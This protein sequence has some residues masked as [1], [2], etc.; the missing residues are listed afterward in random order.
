MTTAQLAHLRA[1]AEAAGRRIDAFLAEQPQLALSRTAVQ[2]LIEAG[3]VRVGGRPVRSSLKLSGGEEIEVRVPPPPAPEARAEDIPLRVVYEDADLIVVDKPRGMVVHPAAGHARGTLVNALLHHCPDLSGVGGE[4]RPGIVHRLDKG[5]TGLIVAAKNDAAHHSLAAQI[6]RR[7]AR[8]EY[9]ALVYGSPDADRGL[10]DAPIGR[11]PAHRQRMAV[12][13]HRGRAARTHFQVRERF[14]G[15]GGSR[16]H[17][18][19][20]C[21]L[22]TGRT[23]QVRVHLASIGHPV[24]ADPLYAPSRPTL[25]LGGQALHAFR[26]AF[27]HPRT[28]RPLRFEVPL[29][30]DFQA[31][32]DNLRAALLR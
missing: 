1:P 15:R 12:V 27:E 2:R 8:R 5:T 28:G 3:R 25:G 14:P 4:L 9:L 31:V 11:D 19:L 20:E 13:A 7:T 22:E 23:H 24:V 30:P 21:R 32:V 6:K 29:P 18:L 16:G 10:I 26:L 17:A